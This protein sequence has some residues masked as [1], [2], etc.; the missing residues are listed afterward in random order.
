LSTSFWSPHKHIILGNDVGIGPRCIFLC[1]TEIGSKVLIAPEVAFLNSDDHRFDVVGKTIWDSGRGDQYK[2]IIE[3]DVWIGYG[4]IILSP[5]K[6][7]RG[8]IVAAGS[9]VTE[10]VPNYS[11]IAGVPAR[12]IKKRFT[13]DQINE[14]ERILGIKQLS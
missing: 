13:E 2:I 8:S 14:H 5:M 9:V 3:D 1:D 6:I 4:S 12:V 7:G 10:D 11:I